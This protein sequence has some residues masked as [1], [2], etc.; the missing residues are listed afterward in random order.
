MTSKVVEAVSAWR[1]WCA[2]GGLPGFAQVS[3]PK[4]TKWFLHF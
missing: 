3:L 2:E 1:G 4:F